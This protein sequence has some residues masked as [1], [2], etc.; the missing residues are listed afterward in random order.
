MLLSLH[1][2]EV[3]FTVF[4]SRNT[5][6]EQPFATQT[7][8]HRFSLRLRNSI[9][10]FIC[11]FIFQS[12][13]RSQLST[14]LIT[15][16]LQQRWHTNSCECLCMCTGTDWHPSHIW[17]TTDA[18]ILKDKLLK[19]WTCEWLNKN[20]IAAQKTVTFFKN[21]YISFQFAN[22]HYLHCFKLLSLICC[23]TACAV[24]HRLDALL[25][26]HPVHNTCCSACYLSTQ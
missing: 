9:I 10:Y 8:Q 21:K 1:F 2:Q 23:C 24:S 12:C 19:V 3:A 26:H 18:F 22:M 6:V 16:M 15:P 25:I 14:K 13:A 17:K 7:A 4:K 5:V 11:I 20:E